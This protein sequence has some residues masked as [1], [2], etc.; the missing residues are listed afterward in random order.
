MFGTRR[1]L[2]RHL[3][4]AASTLAVVALS[5][6]SSRAEDD[7]VATQ[8]R[9]VRA[10]IEL[11]PLDVLIGRLAFVGT[12][13]VAPHHAITATVHGDYMPREAFVF[14]QQGDLVFGGAGAELG[15]HIYPR[16]FD[17]HGFWFGPSA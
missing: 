11:A 13:L 7:V 16:R 15:W 3:V 14:K 5:H 6:D 9:P 4:I 12:M 2:R 10:A 1:M 17:L 8:T